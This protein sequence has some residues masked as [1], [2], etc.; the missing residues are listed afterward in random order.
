M[1]GGVWDPVGGG[2]PADWVNISADAKRGIT[3]AG[4]AP[5]HGVG[6]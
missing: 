6:A 2:E 4:Y 5:L 3:V 1:Q